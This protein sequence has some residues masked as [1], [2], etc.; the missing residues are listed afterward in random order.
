MPQKTTHICIVS[1]YF[2]PH[3]GGVEQYASHLATELARLGHKVSVLTCKVDQSAEHETRSDGVH[4]YRVPAYNIR[5]RFP[6]PTPLFSHSAAWQQL[7]E[8]PIDA[9]MVNT[10]F[11]PL[12]YHALKLAHAKHATALVIEHGSGYLTLGSSVLDKVL[13]TY[14]RHATKRIQ[15]YNPSFYGVSG[16]AAA[17]LK[18]FNI[19]AKGV[20]PNAIDSAALRSSA[21]QRDFRNEYGLSPT[22]PFVAYA[23]RLVAGKGVEVLAHTAKKMQDHPSGIQFFIAGDGPLYAQTDHDA[24]SCL[25][26]L[27]RLS[28]ADLAALLLQADFFCFPSNYPEGMPTSLLEAAACEAYIIT[29][30]VGGVSE[31]I[32][33]H[34]WGT[35]LDAPTPDALQAALTHH[36]TQM[37]K[38]K[39]SAAQCRSHVEQHYSWE[40]S[41]RAAEAAC[42]GNKAMPET[43][44]VTT[45]A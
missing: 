30:N 17:W 45:F 18:T 33:N 43:D 1:S 35:I 20:I 21:S 5:N 24:P 10:R 11:Y 19:S 3:L 26:M 13:N 4:I 38:V 44:D 32:G 39:R 7:Q 28:Q 31:I 12:S 36:L 15:Q 42:F 25:H 6:L 23:G 16:K 8:Q 2:P 27:G 41:A 14:E 22:C 34:G 29:A 37:D 9:V 40:A